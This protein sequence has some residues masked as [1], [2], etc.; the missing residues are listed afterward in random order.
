[1]TKKELIRVVHDKTIMRYEDIN[2]IV[3]TFLDEIKKA[4]NEDGKVI[5]SGFGSFE[6]FTQEEHIGVHPLT[7][8]RLEIQSI[9]KIKFTPSINLKNQINDRK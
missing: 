1:M 8:E 2:L 9:N 3:D 6:K 4:L 7:G 5:L